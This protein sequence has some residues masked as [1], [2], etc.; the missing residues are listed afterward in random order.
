MKESVE[1]R[2]AVHGLLFALSLLWLF[3]LASAL[4]VLVKD[5]AQFD[6][7]AF[8]TLPPLLDVPGNVVANLVEAWVRA[9]VGRYFLNSV[10]Y[11]SIAGI[12]SGLVASLAGFALV[13]LKIKA[14]QAWFLT[15]FIGNLFPF[16]MFL[17]PLYLVLNRTGLYDTVPGLLLVYLGITLPFAL[18]I[19]R[20]YAMTVPRELFEAA[21]VDGASPWRA[22][23]SIF[24]PIT[25]PALIVVFV[26]QFTWTWND[27]LF[28]L[29]LSENARPIMTALSA[30]TGLRGGVP[31]A[32]L[33][34]GSLIAALPPAIVL[35]TLQR[36]F[37]RGFVIGVEKG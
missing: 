35:L 28:G 9:D 8:W 19:Y 29:V 1:L 13:H 21:F 34:A 20:N 23:T 10:L 3:P 12:G 11:A 17:I 16:Q 33:I 18:F 27:L 32:T 15:L 5:A 2:R 25:R 4:V 6:A 7:L 37:V 24:F 14:P 22:F 31:P 26:F 30:L 36:Y